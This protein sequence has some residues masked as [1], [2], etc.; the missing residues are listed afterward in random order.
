MIEKKEKKKLTDMQKA[1]LEAMFSEECKGNI[2]LAMD[3][4]GYSKE[5]R[6]SEVLPG[7]SEHIRDKALEFLTHQSAK[8]VWELVGALGNADQAGMANKIKI[9][10]MMLNRAGVK[11]S[12]KN[13]N[14]NIPQGGIVILPRKEINETSD[15]G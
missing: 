1:L 2:R 4:A 12:D 11:E 8:A 6:P 9:L 7:L 15:E 14:L 5:T 3:A 10:E 13:V